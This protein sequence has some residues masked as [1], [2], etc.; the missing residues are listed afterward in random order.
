MTLYELTDV[1]ADLL[2]RMDVAETD[3][4]YV[5]LWDEM[6]GA[7]ESFRDKAE[8]YAKIML[9]KQAE[10]EA[11]KAEK[12][13]LA[14]CQKSAERAVTTLKD[15][16]L[17]T[18]QILGLRDV[19]TNIGKWRVQ[20]NPPSCEVLNVDD[21]PEEYHIKQADKIDSAGI[22]KNYRLTGEIPNGV[23]ICQQA[24]LRFK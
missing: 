6:D 15:R 21:V 10:A 20:M 17:Y 2:Q 16:L 14:A 9:I 3:E 23:N 19:Q 5:A 4:E 11:F 12:L 7:M 8:A 22:L 24:G 1:C 18:M 13:R